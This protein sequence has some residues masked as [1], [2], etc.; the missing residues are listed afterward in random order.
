[1]TGIFRANNPLNTS[2]LFVYGL[3]LKIPWFLSPSTLSKNNSYGFLYNGLID[4][5]SPAFQ[6]WSLLAPL[7]VYLLLFTQAL[8][9]NFL[10]NKRKMMAKPNYLPAMAYLLIT[11][12]FPWWNELT[13]PLIV[14][15][16]LIWI[17]ARLTNLNMTQGVKTTLFNVGLVIGIC[18]LIYLPALTLL[19]IVILGLLIARPARVTEW[20]MVILGFL[21]VWYFVFAYLFL[22]DKLYSFYLP[23]FAF[24]GWKIAWQPKQFAG[25]VI[26]GICFL[27]G[28]YFVQSQASKQIIQVRKRWT[29][30][31]INVGILLF[32]PFLKN[33]E[34][35]SDWILACLPVS[36]FIAAGFFYLN[37]KWLR[38]IL[39]WSMVAFVLYCQYY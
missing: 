7:I 35:L 20:I 16:L 4:F 2:I 27:V 32:I 39:H 14:N 19:M 17:W 33:H 22:T 25:I 10:I 6:S 34:S 37:S 8:S 30:L 38:L 18:S 24:D 23:G 1:M 5:L 3:L 26:I 13:G 9:L 36:A 31:L 28:A 21:T 11:S 12:F 15:S 29:F